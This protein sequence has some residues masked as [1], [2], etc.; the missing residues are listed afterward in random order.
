L[1]GPFHGGR[2]VARRIERCLR[3]RFQ[4]ALRDQGVLGGLDFGDREGSVRRRI[5]GDCLQG[6]ENI[7]IFL[8]D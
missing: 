6:S 1:E 5:S 2:I 8:D 4:I 7:S 3:L